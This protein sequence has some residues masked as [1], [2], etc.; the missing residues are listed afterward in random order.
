M[1]LSSHSSCKDYKVILLVSIVCIIIFCTHVACADNENGADLSKLSWSVLQIRGDL[2]WA[3]RENTQQYCSNKG[4]DRTN[5]FLITYS[6]PFYLNVV[7][8]Q[9]NKWSELGKESYYK[10]HFLRRCMKS[11]LYIAKEKD[12]Y[13]LSS[14]HFQTDFGVIT[15]L[16]SS[17]SRLVWIPNK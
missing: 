14:G 6:L 15:L 2:I 1:S 12:L 17:Q 8:C 4:H 11:I 3:T 10:P 7:I 13:S 9:W 16:N 5:Y